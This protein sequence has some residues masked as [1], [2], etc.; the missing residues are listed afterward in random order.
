MELVVKGM[1]CG[2]CEAAVRRAVVEIDPDAQV[3][4][5]RGTES[6]IVQSTATAE[7]VAQAIRAGG[8]E[9]TPRA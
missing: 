8:Y 6:V 3:Q 4:I 7:A 2:H 9:A 1:T 5:D